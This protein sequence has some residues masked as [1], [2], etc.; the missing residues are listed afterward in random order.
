ME[1]KWINDPSPVWNEIKDY[2]IDEEGELRKEGK[3][4]GGYEDGKLVAAF[5]IRPWT[6]YCY[7]I[8]GGLHPSCFGRGKEICTEMGLTLFRNTPCL[9]I[10]AIV[11]EYNKK[12]RNCLVACGLNQEGVIK[13]AFLRY[14]R[15]H[16]LY[17]Y[18]ITR[19][20]AIECHQQL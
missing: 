3:F 20:E 1:F 11:P 6:T 10:V 9:K 19:G 18:G 12:M 13:S 5:E 17:V 8:H 2:M 14:M 16:D 7:E 4:L 15:L